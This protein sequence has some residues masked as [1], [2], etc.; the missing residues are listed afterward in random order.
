MLGKAISRQRI[1][2]NPSAA[3]ALLDP[4]GG[5]YSPPANPLAGVEGLAAPPQEPHLPALGHH[6]SYPN[7]KI[8]SD[9]V[10][11]ICTFCYDDLVLECHMYS[12]KSAMLMLL[13]LEPDVNVNGYLCCDQNTKGPQS[14][15]Q[16]RNIYRTCS[17]VTA[18]CQSMIM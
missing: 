9:A 16:L 3:G 12:T 7:C 1:Q 8:S 14:F 15:L 5:A 4:A 13:G 6:L 18:E 2:E 17:A 11:Q 10:G